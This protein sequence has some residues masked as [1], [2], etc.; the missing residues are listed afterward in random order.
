MSASET[1]FLDLKPELGVQ[2]SGFA[3]TAPSLGSST[4]R[5][6]YKRQQDARLNATLVLAGGA[7]ASR[8]SNGP[9]QQGTLSVGNPARA[10][11]QGSR[12]RAT[13]VVMRRPGTIV[14]VA[15]VCAL[16]SSRKDSTL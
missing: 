5:E 16:V 13:A 2:A 7:R 1:G 10:H 8:S 11:G 9:A 6:K 3:A 12:F 14:A 15:F 4:Q